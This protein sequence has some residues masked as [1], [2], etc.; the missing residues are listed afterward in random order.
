M[1]AKKAKAIRR[2]AREAEHRALLR[3]TDM[4]PDE[5]PPSEERRRI[6]RRAFERLLKRNAK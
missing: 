1:R 3:F 2:L 4:R 5:P 6:A